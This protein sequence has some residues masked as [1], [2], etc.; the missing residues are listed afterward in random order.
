MIA[1]WLYELK[2][3][4]AMDRY[5][6]PYFF[7]MGDVA[8]RKYVNVIGVKRDLSALLLRALGVGKRQLLVQM[9]CTFKLIMFKEKSE[10]I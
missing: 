7:M 5:I 9:Y 4:T 1:R 2:A 6:F 8:L 10:R 3:S